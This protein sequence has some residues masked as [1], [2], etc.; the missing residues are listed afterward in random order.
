M[1]QHTKIGEGVASLFRQLIEKHLIYIQEMNSSS[2]SKM[3][4]CDFF[5]SPKL[6]NG[7]ALQLKKND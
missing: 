6:S 5:V 7:F 1:Q 2:E 4:S 3:A